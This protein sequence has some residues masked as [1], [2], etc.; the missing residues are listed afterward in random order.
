MSIKNILLLQ[1][2][3]D[4]HLKIIELSKENML[5]RS[6]RVNLQNNVQSSKGGSMSRCMS[7]PL[8]PSSI[9]TTELNETAKQAIAQTENEVFHIFDQID[10]IDCK[11]NKKK[12]RQ[13]EAALIAH[14]KPTYE[15]LRK[16]LLEF[17]QKKNPTFA[18]VS[19][20]SFKS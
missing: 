3:N 13:F 17:S 15:S 18:E 20:K 4:S 5:L 2:I 6:K 8:L 10:H 16:D 19:L 12:V 1:K 7:L 11:E 9:K 14:K